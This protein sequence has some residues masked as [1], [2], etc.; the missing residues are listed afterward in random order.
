MIDSPCQIVL[1]SRRERI[2]I[3][4][5]WFIT[6]SVGSDGKVSRHIVGTIPGYALEGVEGLENIQ[7]LLSKPS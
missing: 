5:D 1:I 6:Q 3:L 2:P 7:F 4:Y